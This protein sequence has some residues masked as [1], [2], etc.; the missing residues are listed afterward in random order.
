MHTFMDAV[1]FSRASG[2]FQDA[3]LLFVY[4]VY[5]LFNP[6]WKEERTCERELLLHSAD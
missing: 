2:Y 5:Y 6:N 1:F 4:W 3:G